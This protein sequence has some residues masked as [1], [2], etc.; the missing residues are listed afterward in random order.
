MQMQNHL[1]AIPLLCSCA[2]PPLCHVSAL[3]TLG[4]LKKIEITY[5]VIEGFKKWTDLQK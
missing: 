4:A 3:S 2:A 5:R 1:Y